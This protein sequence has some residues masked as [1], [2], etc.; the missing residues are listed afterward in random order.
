M[1]VDELIAIATGGH[2]DIQNDWMHATAVR[3]F[4]FDDPA[5]VWLEYHGEENGFKPDKSPYDFLGFISGKGRQFEEKWISELASTA[6]VVCPHDYEVRS[7]DKV[8]ETSKHI[9]ARTPV[10]AKPA[11]WAAK[12]RVYGVPDLIVHTSWLAAAFPQFIGQY[13]RDSIA[14]NLD[15]PDKP[16]HYVALDLKFTTGL[17]E[18]DKKKDYANYSTQV[19]IYSY[20]LGR[21]QGLM[22]RNAYLVTRDRVSDP[23]PVRITSTLGE[24][25]D[26]DLA[27]IRDHFADIKL[28]GAGYRPWKDSIV[29]SNLSSDSEMWAKA[30]ESIAVEKFP[31]RDPGL[32]YNIGP[33]IKPEL[34]ALGFPSLDSMLGVDPASI[35]FEKCR[36]LGPKK[37]T[38]MRAILRSNRSGNAIKPAA[39]VLPIQ[40]KNE[41]F[42]DF[43]YF[44]NVNVD[45]QKQWP[46]LDGHEMVFMIGAGRNTN[47]GWSFRSF[48]SGGENPERE[49]EMFL[50]FIDF[51][52]RETECTETDPSKTVLYH[53]TGAEVWQAR[54]SSDR[55]AFPPDHS[56]RTLPWCDLQKPFLEGPGAIPGAWAFGLKELSNA[57]GALHP[58]MAV[59]W[60]EALH[61]G[62][63]AMVMGWQAYSNVAPLESAEMTLLRKY[64]EVD[65]AALAA[66]L[67]WLRA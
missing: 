28:H 18:A 25:L 22:P 63:R 29:A 67:R 34:L 31:G 33:S 59:Q 1:P 36:G 32:L 19:R 20:M 11:L 21:L 61:A 24:P 52:H 37:S 50:E 30:K 48:V 49:R 66:V 40:K 45:F 51:L 42:V 55:L 60:P 17:D 16:G 47:E 53:W 46:T 39:S 4:I 13:E 43:E 3:P 12:E 54:R 38:V 56:L 57:L 64:L 15:P 44:T 58:A 8:V 27:A 2:R 65:C 23:L 26:G 7:F 62:L 6:V 10:I 35:P 14:V 9:Y 5:L 41:F